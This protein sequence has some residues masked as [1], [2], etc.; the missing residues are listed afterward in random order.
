MQKTPIEYLDM[1]WNPIAMRCTPWSRGCWNCWHLR[2]ANRHGNN[3]IFSPSARRAYAGGDPWLNTDELAA[4]LRRRKPARIGVQFMG[5]LFNESISNEWI[6]SVFGVMAAS[7]QH[8][9]FILTKRIERSAEWYQW[10]TEFKDEW[11]NYNRVTEWIEDEGYEFMPENCVERL[12]GTYFGGQYGDEGRCE[13]SPCYENVKVDWPLPNVILGVSVENQPSADKRIPLL[14]QV[15]AAKRWVSYE[16]ALDE[17]DFRYVAPNEDW[18]I[19]ALATPDESC[20]VNLV[21][22]GAETGPDARPCNLDNL[23]SARDQCAD[24][25]VPFFL[26]TVNAKGDRE[27]DGRRHEEMI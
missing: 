5:D 14:L 4:P 13:L 12:G 22:A 20:R 15:P 2:M 27:L 19:D 1:T 25:G 17:V 21:V 8:T 26:K 9:F 18:H 23:R 11:E 6:T 24:A 7:P 3:Y 10:A 16:P